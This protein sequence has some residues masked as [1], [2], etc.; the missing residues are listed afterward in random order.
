M[1]RDVFDQSAA[2]GHLL[3]RAHQV[4]VDL[5][6]AELGAAELGEARPTPQQFA[7]LLMVERHPGASQ[8]ELVRLT[9][10]DRSTLAEMARRLVTRGLLARQRDRADARANKLRVT[11]AGRRLVARVLPAV[12]RSQARVLALLPARRRKAFIADLQCLVRAG[13]ALAVD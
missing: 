3:R 13:E 4:S 9:G 10:I 12:A 11:P 5:F 6:V 1:P 7:L 8:T 2:P